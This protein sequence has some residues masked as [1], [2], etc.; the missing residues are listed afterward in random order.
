MRPDMSI[1]RRTVL[2]TAGALAAARSRAAEKTR[3]TV[4]HAMSAAL[5]EELNKL[6]DAFNASQDSVEVTGLFK[7]AYKDLMTAMVAAYRAGQAPHVAQVFEVGTETMLS[8][9]PVIKPLWRLAQE[10]G[11][12]IDPNRYISA[13]RGYYS[14]P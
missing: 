13:V 7:G 1:T 5:G 3:I 8:S 14:T 6:I 9:G 12:A 4:W 2:A 10:T 11:V